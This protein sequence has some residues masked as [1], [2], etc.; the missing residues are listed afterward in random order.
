VFGRQ[1][2]VE[3]EFAQRNEELFKASFG[4]QFISGLIM[5]LMMFIGNLSFVAV[6]VIGGLRVASGDLNLG[7]V[8]AFIQYQRM[9]T[10]PLAQIGS[11]ANLLQSGVASAERVFE[12][13]DEPEQSPEAGGEL[14]P[15]RGQVTFHDVDFSYSADAELIT[16]LNLT[17]EPG[18]TVAIVGPTG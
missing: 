16:G 14:L 11:M 10:Q 4:A 8:Q 3:K 13:L 12:I 5:P 15:T 2:E 18:Q 7:S 17:V 9:F 1:R 6:A